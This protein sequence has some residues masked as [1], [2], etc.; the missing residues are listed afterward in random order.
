VAA[1]YV[2]PPKLLL[3]L[4]T[5]GTV[6]HVEVVSL[7]NGKLTFSGDQEGC[8][9]PGDTAVS[10]RAILQGRDTAWHVQTPQPPEGGTARVE[11]RSTI[12]EAEWVN[13]FEV[14]LPPA[15]PRVYSF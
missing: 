12:G 11:V 4:I 3:K 10:V 5:A 7:D 9:Y 6:E 2:G 14:K 15:P 13:V 8:E 1:G